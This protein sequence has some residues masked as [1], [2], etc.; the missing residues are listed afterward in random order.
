[1]TGSGANRPAKQLFGLGRLSPLLLENPQKIQRIGVIRS[2]AENTFAT[3]LRFQQ[4]SLAMR[5]PRPRE[6]GRNIVGAGIAAGDRSRPAGFLGVVAQSA[7]SLS[8]GSD[9][10][11]SACCHEE[12]DDGLATLQPQGHGFQGRDLLSLI[13]I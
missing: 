3:G 6:P 12:A 4:I 8:R 1:M 5:D 13:H 11:G 2:T 9:L 10:E 7:S